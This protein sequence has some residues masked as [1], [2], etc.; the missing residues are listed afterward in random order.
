[1]ERLFAKLLAINILALLLMTLSQ[2]AS[3][4][5]PAADLP[6]D[7]LGV[8]VGM[9]KD[10]A[11]KRLEEVAQF[12]S[13]DR[14][15]G[16][17]WLTKND[18]RFKHLAVAY[19]ANNQIRFV[20]AMVEK[21]TAKERVRFAEVGDL[22]QAEKQV[23]AQHHK[24]YWD[25]PASEGKPAYKIFIYGDDPDFLTIYSLSKKDDPGES[26]EKK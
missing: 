7:I 18:P 4:A 3:K 2:C 12:V 1:M 23:A 25:V 20:T 8:S 14:E 9:N 13:E 5:T 24:Y 16:Q 22:G 6:K 10:E 26:K 17:L 19:D 21:A 11:R 15:T